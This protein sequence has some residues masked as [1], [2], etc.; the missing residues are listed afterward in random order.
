MFIAAF[1]IIASNGKQPRCPTSKDWIQK[2]WCICTLEHYSSIKSDDLMK[3]VG[4]FMVL[5]PNILSEVNQS[6]KAMLGMS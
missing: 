2:M 3:L 5:E 4:K 1:F 6:Q